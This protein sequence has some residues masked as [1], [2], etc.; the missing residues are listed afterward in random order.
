MVNV[1]K[2]TSPMDP[3]GIHS[4][5]REITLEVDP[6]RPLVKSSAIWD[7]QINMFCLDSMPM[8]LKC[9]TGLFFLLY[10]LRKHPYTFSIICVYV[11]IFI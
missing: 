1:G 9:R 8:A 10:L 11:Y 7:H 5:A 2:Y 6:I 3:M 4:I